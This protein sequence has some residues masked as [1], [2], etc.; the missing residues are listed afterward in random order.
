M[1]TGR[2]L[3]A[4]IVALGIPLSRGAAQ[5]CQ[6]TAEFQ[7]GRWRAG[8]FEHDNN[9]VSDYGGALAFGVPRSFY[10]EIS[11]D[12]LQDA[13][14]GPSATGPGLSVGYQIHLSD[15]P[16]Q[17]CPELTA[18]FWSGDGTPVKYGVGGSLGYRFGIN[19]WFTVVP[20]AGIRWM[21]AT[22]LTGINV[23]TVGQPAGAGPTSTGASQAIVLG[24]SS[25]VHMELGLVFHRTFTIVP[26]LLVPSQNGTSSIFTLGVSINWPNDPSR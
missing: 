22:T 13:H 18:H 11:Y 15:T 3:T 1:R 5:T 20:A 12:K 14:E 10:G 24:S 8:A 7:D 25:E 19:H 16:F 6:G 2:L 4:V 9:S 17:V 23:L 21:T 26:G